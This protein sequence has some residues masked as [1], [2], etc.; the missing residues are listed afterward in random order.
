MNFGMVTALF[1]F[2]YEVV[3]SII[4]VYLYAYLWNR[5]LNTDVTDV[6]ILSSQDFCDIAK[7]V[8]LR[9]EFEMTK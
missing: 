7:D 3:F 2:L 1:I 6:H 4:L 9:L 8:F 5:Y